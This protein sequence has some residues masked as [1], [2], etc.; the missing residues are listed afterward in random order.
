MTYPRRRLREDEE[1]ILERGLHPV[2]L[3]PSLLIALVAFAALGIGFVLWRNAPAWFGVILGVLLVVTMG[4]ALVSFLR[5][6]SIQLVLT[7]QRLILRSGVL[8]RSSNDIPLRSVVTVVSHQTFL[9]RLM[10]IGDLE[11]QASGLEKPALLHDIQSPGQFVNLVHVATEALEQERLNALVA[12]TGPV[13]VDLERRRLS[14]LFRK[15]VITEQEYEDHVRALGI[16]AD[17]G[18]DE[19]RSTGRW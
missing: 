12:R 13:D 4:Y 9:K 7:T 10:R 19:K 5:Y 11:I 6:R 17:V 18:D 2:K 15:G 14:A 3:L 16:E 1:I 8:R